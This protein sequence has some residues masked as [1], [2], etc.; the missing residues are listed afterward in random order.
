MHK[1]SWSLHPRRGFCKFLRVS[2]YAGRNRHFS[3]FWVGANFECDWENVSRLWQYAN[4]RSSP[5]YEQQIEL[6]SSLHLCHCSPQPC[7]HLSIIFFFC[8][9]SFTGIRKRA[10]TSV[11][12]GIKVYL[13]FKL[14]CHHPPTA[15][16]PPQESSEERRQRRPRIKS[17][18]NKDQSRR[19]RHPRPTAL[20]WKRSSPNQMAGI[21]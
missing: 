9:S 16:R 1:A 11:F 10:Q 2:N 20:S 5:Y 3:M 7:R 4:D 13:S 15:S 14:Q 21:Q 8:F 17:V 12:P 6:V 19:A 18:P